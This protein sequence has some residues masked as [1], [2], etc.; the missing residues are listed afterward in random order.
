MRIA[1]F[2]S[3]SGHSGVDK[4]AEL[5]VPQL[6]KLGYQVDILKVRKH[7]PNLEKSTTTFTKLNIIDLKTSHTMTALNAIKKYLMTY[8]PDALLSDKDRCNR[9]AL[10]AKLLTKSNTKVS[11]SSG[12]IMSENLKNRSWLEVAF[13]KLS[14]NYLYPYAYSIITPSKDAATDLASVSSIKNEK[15]TVVPLPIISPEFLKLSTENVDHPWLNN[16]AEKV[17]IS[18]GELNDRKDQST[19]LRAFAELSKK[20]ACKLLIIGKGKDENI[21][22]LLAKE[23]DIEE[24]VDFLGFKENPYK[25][26]QKADIF[27]HTAK[28]EGFGMVMVEALALGV[29]CIAANCIGGPNEILQDGKLGKLVPVGDHSS[30]AKAIIETLQNPIPKETLI[31]S[32]SKYTVEQSTQAY[33]N[34]MGL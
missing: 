19:Q 10:L 12:T 33:L 3:T 29:P 1:I 11:V 5:M 16:K 21:L 23:L 27:I 32:V 25:Y 24:K 8:K 9:V 22:K 18:V 4:T 30:L 26:I 20:I 6:L 28:F 14:F 13:H 17:I 31:N 34:T 15:I 7:G 2:F